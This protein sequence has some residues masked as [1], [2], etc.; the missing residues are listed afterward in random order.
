MEPEESA[1]G[2]LAVIDKA[3]EKNNGRFYGYD[4]Q[5]VAW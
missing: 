3:T 4:G 5:E 1:T 2:I